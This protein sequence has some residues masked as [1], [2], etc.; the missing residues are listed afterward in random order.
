MPSGEKTHVVIAGGGVAA[1]EA[2][3]ALQDMASELVTVELIAPELHFWY[4]PLSVAEPFGLGESLRYELAMLAERAGATYTPGTLEA[5]DADRHVAR[6]SVGDIPYD[7]LLVATGARSERAVDG[8]TMTFRGPADVEPLTRILRQ[9]ESGAVRRVAFVVP[10][11]ATWA[12]PAY[13]LA[14][15]TAVRLERL[16]LEGSEVVLVTTEDEPLELFGPAASA[17]VASL[18]QAY[19]IEFHAAVHPRVV[20]EDELWVVPAGKIQADAVIALPRLR[21]PRI[22]GLPQNVSGFIPVD[23]HGRV[24]GVE[25]VYAAGDSTNFPLKQ[26]GIAAQQAL[27]A[28]QAIGAAA[29]AAVEPRP[30]D[31]V[32]RG[33]LLT[34]RQPQF[35]RR[36]LSTG[37][38]ESSWASTDAL[39][40]PPA[41]IVGRFVGPLLAELSGTAARVSEPMPEGSVEVEVELDRE[42]V[43]R[44]LRLEIPDSAEDAGPRVRDLMATDLVIVE[45]EDTLGLAAELMH[46]HDTGSAAVTMAGRLVGILTSRDMLRAFAGRAHPSEARAR[47]WMTAEPIVVGPE[48]TLEAAMMLMT[49]YGIHHLP[50]VEDDRPVGMLGLRQAA[51]HQQP[52]TKVGLGL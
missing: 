45:P 27:A 50:V 49:E 24:V 40:W 8:A 43:E 11:G 47:E 41:K 1:L 20:V 3:L 52:P 12:L 28:A 10:W 13:E 36:D 17:T 39:W 15:M 44:L 16:E 48:S 19:G 22:A 31:P 9:V 18:L 7:V 29:G 38:A 35:L 30:F 34:G 4:R 33:L 21:G 25:D 6:T 51:R 37:V 26:G 5:V 42:A 14:L 23:Q 2:A 46:D 32:L